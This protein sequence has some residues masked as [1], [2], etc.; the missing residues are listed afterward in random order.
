MRHTNADLIFARCKSIQRK[1]CAVRMIPGRRVLIAFVIV[2]IFFFLLSPLEIISVNWNSI[3]IVHYTC[4][5][6]TKVANVSIETSAII[7]F[8]NIY[9]NLIALNERIL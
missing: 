6:N 7:K 2:G 9:R 4:S 8:E 3:L 1:W 5:D